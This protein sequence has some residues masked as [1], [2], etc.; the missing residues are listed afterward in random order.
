[1]CLLES[2]EA[3]DAVTI[4]CLAST[5]RDQLNPLRFKGRLT[6]PAGLE[7]AAQAMGTHVGLVDGDSRTE[8]RIGLVGSVRDVV[9][10]T[11]R[12]DD[13]DGCLMVSATRLLAGEQGYM[14]HFTLLHGVRKLIEGR[15][16]IFIK[17]AAS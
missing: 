1:M 15:A 3:W 2:V 16:S 17:A 7:Y 13:L 9:F 4:R 8:H 11:D 12:L 5:H 10:A 14:Y 6:A